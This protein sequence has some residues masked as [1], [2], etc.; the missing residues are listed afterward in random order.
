MP[1]HVVYMYVCVFL[2]H[3]CHV[4]MLL[5]CVY[6]TRLLQCQTFFRHTW[7]DCFLQLFVSGEHK[8]LSLSVTMVCY[9]G[10]KPSHAL[11]STESFLKDCHVCYQRLYTTRFG[12]SRRPV[13]VRCIVR[14]WYVHYRVLSNIFS[15]S[16]QRTP[17]S[18][19]SPNNL[20]L[21][22]PVQDCQLAV[23]D[24]TF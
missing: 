22:S 11:Y 23:C 20:I 3:D 24:E 18:L 13:S 10:G 14:P 19:Q 8:K 21:W 16:R 7:I 5:T 1:H 6:T 4:F 12:N 2:H 15:M 17:S 9:F